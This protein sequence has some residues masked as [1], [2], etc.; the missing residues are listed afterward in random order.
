[1][2][3]ENSALCSEAVCFWTGREAPLAWRPCLGQVLPSEAPT[4]PQQ[5][6][7]SAAIT[8]P[9]SCSCWQLQLTANEVAGNVW[10]LQMT[11]GSRGGFLD[12]ACSQHHHNCHQF[13]CVPTDIQNT[14][15]NSVFFYWGVACCPTLTTGS[16]C[17]C[18]SFFF[19]SYCIQDQPRCC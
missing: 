7:G 17:H 13:H 18:S 1:M 16:F 10:Q 3:D 2:K 8:R 15:W 6:H 12:W 19:I 11:V 14:L 4:D 5:A 9:G